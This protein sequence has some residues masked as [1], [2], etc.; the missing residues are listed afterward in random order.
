MWRKMLGLLCALLASPPFP[1]PFISHA[2][3][4]MLLT[5]QRNVSSP[6]H[7]SQAFSSPSTAR[8]PPLH[9]S[10]YLPFLPTPTCH[11]HLPSSLHGILF[12]CNAGLLFPCAKYN[13]WLYQRAYSF[14]FSSS[15]SALQ[16][17]A[18]SL[19]T[20]VFL[21]KYF[22]CILFSSE[23]HI[24][25]PLVRPIAPLTCSLTCHTPDCLAMP[26]TWPPRS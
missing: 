24:T 15:L 11:A 1:L 8:I 26:Q 20:C 18:I 6:I 17:L 25:H 23:S 7:I 22:A 5:P 10:T 2:H 12:S 16:S 3:K 19:S 21:I 14:L 13:T 4:F 9:A